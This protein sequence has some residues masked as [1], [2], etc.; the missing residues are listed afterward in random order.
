MPGT[1]PLAL[2]I[3]SQQLESI[4]RDGNLLF[5]C[6]RQVLTHRLAK[7][8]AGIAQQL[9]RRADDYQQLLVSPAGQFFKQTR[10]GQMF[11]ADLQAFTAHEAAL[12]VARWV[13]KDAM[14]AAKAAGK[15]TGYRVGTWT[16]LS[17]DR[18]ESAWEIADFDQKVAAIRLHMVEELRLAR[19]E[20]REAEL[21]TKVDRVLEQQSRASD[22]TSNGGPPDTLSPVSPA[23]PATRSAEEGPSYS[24]IRTPPGEIIVG[25]E[26]VELAGLPWK[27][28][29][30][31]RK[32]RGRISYGRLLETAWGGKDDPDEYKKVTDQISILRGK[33]R[34]SKKPQLM[35]LAERLQHAKD[36][37]GTPYLRLSTPS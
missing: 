34:A 32:A 25:G 12:V 10:G 11:S 8:V 6:V 36:D 28:M 20:L 5:D 16:I 23:E 18:V 31:L 17:P 26:A 27:I 30:E 7:N 1:A 24:G 3:T 19:K 13:A 9:D 22:P 35:A 2:A 15:A 33:L 4:H 37:D 21:T 14:A 29:A